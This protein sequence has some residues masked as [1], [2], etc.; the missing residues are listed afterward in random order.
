M[1]DL[2]LGIF[3]LK[4]KHCGPTVARYWKADLG[5]EWFSISWCTDRTGKWIWQWERSFRLRRTHSSQCRKPQLTAPSARALS[6]IPQCLSVP[7]SLLLLFSF[8][9]HFLCNSKPH[10]LSSVVLSLSFFLFLPPSLLPKK[11]SL[12]GLANSAPTS[13]P[14]RVKP[15]RSA[16]T[17]W[18]R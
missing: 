14:Y 8:Q 17:V 11:G 10:P 1:R 2:F 15:V 6:L 4:L 16:Q 9:Q 7:L 13:V 3:L 5:T 18:L 12:T